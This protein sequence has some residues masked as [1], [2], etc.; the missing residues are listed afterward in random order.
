MEGN[1]HGII[2]GA[3][4]V[5]AW[6]DWEKPQKTSVRIA[7]LQAEIWPWD[8]SHMKQKCQPLSRDVW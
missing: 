8:L 2:E 5:F 6:M 3:I 7:N 1:S 4:L